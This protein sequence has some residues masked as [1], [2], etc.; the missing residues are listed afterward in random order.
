MTAILNDTTLCAI[1]RDEMMNPA[2]GIVRFCD[3]VLPHVEQAVI[4]DTG[5]TDGTLEELE[6]IRSKFPHLTVKSRH[7]DGYASSRNFSLNH[8][9]TKFILVLDA[10]EVIRQRD[11]AN[12]AEFTR[13]IDADW[14]DFVGLNFKFIRV[15]LPGE[16]FP[17]LGH[18][19]RLFRNKPQFR[20]DRVQWEQLYNAQG[21]TVARYCD[22]IDIRIYN[23]MASV[24]ADNIK[25]REWYDAIKAA[26]NTPTDT[27]ARI[28]QL[29]PAQAPY[30]FM[31]KAYNPQRERYES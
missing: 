2:G 5:S 10:D 6:K 19:P 30:F 4:V 8:A 27:D 20:Y 31:W 14:N 28:K 26:T 3:S 12:I 18:N 11:Y 7:F 21:H 17:Q 16:E 29:S 1:V 9:K 15:G 25:K 13:T 24:E 23:F 22:N